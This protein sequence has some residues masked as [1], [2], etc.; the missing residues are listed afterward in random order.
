MKVLYT[1]EVTAKGGREGKIH[2]ADGILDLILNKPKEMNGP[3]NGT[4]PEQ[5]FAGGYAAC[6]ESALRLAAH[7]NG[8]SV[9]NT[10]IT[11]RVALNQTQDEKFILS[12]EL[13]GKIEGYS[14]HDTLEL[15]QQAHQICPYSQAIRNNVEVKL[16][17]E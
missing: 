16:I 4:N 11:A 6:F 3:G 1:A 2:S 15:M 8:K 17:A 7:K 5:L 13:H 10:S 12:V 9:K 14:Q